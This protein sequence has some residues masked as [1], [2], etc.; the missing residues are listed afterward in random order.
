MQSVDSSYDIIMK[1]E[2]DTCVGGLKETIGL[3]IRNIG[4]ITS[5]LTLIAVRGQ[6]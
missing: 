4:K 5:T 6:H 2:A 1:V 3:G